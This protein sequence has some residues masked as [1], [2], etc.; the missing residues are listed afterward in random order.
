[1]NKKTIIILL[2]FVFVKI[3]FCDSSKMMKSEGTIKII[4]NIIKTIDMDNLTKKK[5]IDI[6]GKDASFYDDYY[7]NVGFSDSEL[8]KENGNILCVK[9]KD[10]LVTF[11]YKN[12]LMK[13]MEEIPKEIF[14]R[15]L[16]SSKNHFEMYD[17]LNSIFFSMF[18]YVNDRERIPSVS[19]KV[20]LKN[21]LFFMTAYDYFGSENW[22]N[23][24]FRYLKIRINK[25]K[26]K[27]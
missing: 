14:I 26:N 8:K 3:S 21:V 2:F 25:L 15:F 24:K 22:K 18:S 7:Y 13:A 10:L 12:H 27:I 23:S 5:M 11:Y 1:M 4:V 19:F 6:F 9:K 20:K 17:M 16:I